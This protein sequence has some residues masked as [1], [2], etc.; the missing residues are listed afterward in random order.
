MLSDDLAHISIMQPVLFTLHKAVRLRLFPHIVQFL[1]IFLIDDIECNHDEFSLFVSQTQEF[2]RRSMIS[3][4]RI[5]LLYYVVVLL[6]C[7]H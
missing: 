6:L 2:C 1:E 3:E 7:S 4:Q 5:P